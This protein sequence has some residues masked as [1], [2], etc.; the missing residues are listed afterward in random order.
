MKCNEVYRSGPL[1][2]GHKFG[3]ASLGHC[4]KEAL[5]GF[6]VCFDHVNK[7]ALWMMI[8]Y[9]DHEIKKLKGPRS[10]YLD[11]PRTEKK[12]K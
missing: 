4:P 7:E 9:K 2:E 5:E 6:V 3:G 8:Q 11:H 12:V 10:P 1:F